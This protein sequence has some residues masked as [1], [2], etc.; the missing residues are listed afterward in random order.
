MGTKRR[1]KERQKERKKEMERGRETKSES[2]MARSSLVRHHVEWINLI[3][4]VTDHGKVQAAPSATPDG[5]VARRCLL[6]LTVL[7]VVVVP[8]VGGIDVPCCELAEKHLARPFRAL[9]VEVGVCSTLG[10]VDGHAPHVLGAW[11]AAATVETRL[12]DSL[13]AGGAMLRPDLVL[14]FEVAAEPIILPPYGAIDDT[15]DL[16]NCLAEDVLPASVASHARLVAHQVH[17]IVELN[18]TSLH[19]LEA[20]GVLVI[21]VITDLVPL[22]RV[23]HFGLLRQSPAQP[24]A[25][26]D[27]QQNL[28]QTQ[29]RIAQRRE[30]HRED[31]VSNPGPCHLHLEG[32]IGELVR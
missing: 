3:V 21:I 17:D 8:G 1:R 24:L 22:H 13:G 31:R 4:L 18:T 14:Q 28:A 12:T 15:L 7:D 16:Q 29:V 9:R 19:Q 10:S 2:A 27:P 32:N 25:H 5:V 26:P 20:E 30:A 6:Q 23:L 11:S